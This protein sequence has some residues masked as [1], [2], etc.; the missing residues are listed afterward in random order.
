MP[1]A[2]EH[3]TDAGKDITV[4]VR[5]EDLEVAP[6]GQGIAVTVDVVEELGADAYIYGSTK[7]HQIDIEGD[8]ESAKPF[9]AR[10]DGRRPPEKGQVIHLQVPSRGTSTCSTPSRA[11]ASATDRIARVAPGRHP[12]GCRP[13]AVLPGAPVATEVA[14]R[15]RHGGT[16]G[17]P[18]LPDDRDTMGS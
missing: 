8:E 2:R 16:L 1:I 5:P 13:G 9:I 7:A 14:P 18:R 10:V 3:M 6:D 11:S 15:R 17:G 12:R 4:G